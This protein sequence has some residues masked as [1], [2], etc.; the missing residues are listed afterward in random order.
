MVVDAVYAMAHAVHKTIKNYCDETEFSKCDAVQEQ[1]PGGADLLRDIRNVSFIGM[2][3]TQVIVYIQ[4]ST[5]ISYLIWANLKI[6][7][8]LSIDE[9]V[10]REYFSRK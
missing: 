8:H 2:Q 10:K 9:I 7:N 3:G 5:K 4:A 6:Y 1:A